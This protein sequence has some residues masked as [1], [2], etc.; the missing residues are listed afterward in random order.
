[1][2]SDSPEDIRDP[3]GD[4]GPETR[5]SDSEI[6]RIAGGATISFGGR[7][8]GA[9]LKYVT[10]LV[11]ALWLGAELFGHYA[12][13][14]AIYQF[15]ELAGV[16]G[17]LHG[18][19]RFVAA[20]LQTD[21]AQRLK[22]VLIRGLQLPFLLGGVVGIALALGADFL[23]ADVFGQPALVPLLKVFALALP[24]AATMLV[25]ASA[26]T[27][28]EI[29]QYL[30]IVQEIIQPG[31]NLLLIVCLLWVGAGLV[32]AALAW[33]IAS[34]L[35]MLAGVYFVRRLYPVLAD[36]D[37]SPTF[38]TGALLRYSAPLALG[39][40]SW[41]LMLWTDV[42]V[43]G[44]VASP[45]DVGIY[46]A[47]SQTALSI[48]LFLKAINTI[49]A[50]MIAR[51]FEG[52][53]LGRMASTLETATRWSL[54]ASLPLYVLMVVAP[55][56]LL[57]VFGSEFRAGAVAL[58]ILASG[59]LINAGAGGV[60]YTLMMSGRQT[61]KMVGDVV[62]AVINVCLNILLVPT[63]GIEGAAAATGFSIAGLN[64]TRAVQVWSGLG[65]HAYSGRYL[66][67]MTS[68]LVAMAGGMLLKRFVQAPHFLIS[69]ALSAV[70]VTAVYFTCMW[71]LGFEREDGV[72]Y[73]KIRERLAR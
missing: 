14:F 69:L 29:T 12:L 54:L 67:L 52:D 56:D 72:V 39:E 8:L 2:S 40:A 20:H 71:T 9:V 61:Q 51:Q 22:G 27:A 55:G 28:R 58:I 46:R 73:R 1:M 36:T 66:K 44:M 19:V 4:R 65:I 11:I 42:I 31:V 53:D 48:P 64:I 63:W 34:A 10:Q 35:A 45:D 33:V 59:Q 17:V 37:V 21:D 23:A 25:A 3:R 26:T 62:F 32:G 60:G 41:L 15:A 49:F 18:I 13:G 50:P 47:V 70:V 30:V 16:F 43:L 5:I 68:G 24:F 7:A 6:T 38:E 57:R